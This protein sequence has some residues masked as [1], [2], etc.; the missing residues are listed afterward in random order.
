MA[1]KRHWLAATLVLASTPLAGL[2]PAHAAG[3]VCKLQITAN[4]L[5]QYDKKNLSVGLSC[6]QIEVT[7][8]DVGK[9]PAAAMGHNWVL[10]K[11]ADLS[12]VAN[13]GAAAGFSNNYLEPGDP[14]V[15]AATKIV[16]GGQSA[17]V[18]FAASKLVKGGSYVYLCTF[19]GHNALMRGI[20][21]YD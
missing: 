12:A 10:V 16:G 17:S 15:I 6:A 13:A 5:M 7:L 4:D 8:T 1:A 21:H 14:R 19:P 18:T 9:L 3:T 11:S 2:G 20:F